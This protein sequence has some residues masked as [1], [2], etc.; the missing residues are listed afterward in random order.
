MTKSM[1]FGVVVN[2]I[3]LIMFCSQVGRNGIGER[4]E[5]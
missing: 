1:F 3:S 4:R 5:K 2:F